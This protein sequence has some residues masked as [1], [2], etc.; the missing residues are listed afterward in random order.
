MN[1]VKPVPFKIPSSIITGVNSVNDN[2]LDQVKGFGARRALIVSDQALVKTGYVDELKSF[3][4]DIE[5]AVYTN[6]EPEPS[7]ENMEET[8]VWCDAQKFDVVIGLGGGSVMDSAKMLAALLAHDGH[9]RDYVGGSKVFGKFGAP[10]IMIPTTSGTG[11]EVTVNVV[12]KD[13]AAKLKRVAVSQ[14][15]MPN[16]AIVD[17]LYTMTVPAG[18]TAAT[19]MDALTHAIEAYTAM[20]ANPITDIFAEDA[21]LRIGRSIRTAVTSGGNVEARLDMS[22]GSLFGGIANAGASVGAVHALSY[23]LCG[24]FNLSHGVGNALMLPYVA[25]F[26]MMGNIKKYARVAALLGE[27]V[28]GQSDR[29]AAES[30]VKSIKRLSEDIGIPLHMNKFGITAEV[31]PRWAKTVMDTQARLLNNNPRQLNEKDVLEIYEAA[32]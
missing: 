6:I 9:V 18:V 15:L 10:T 28:D 27:V 2:L 23:P 25:A 5:T 21:I 12:F 32:L 22:L 14:Y 17:P 26:N 3:L 11:A 30:A 8:L 29:D 19:G 4:K 1:I 16:V 7:I 31:L 24:E 20:K 13:K